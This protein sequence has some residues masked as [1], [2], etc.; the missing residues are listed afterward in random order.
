[1]SS[2]TTIVAS[3]YRIQE[4]A[5]QIRDC[6]NRPSGMSVADWCTRNGITKANYYY[7]LR[8]VRAACLENIPEQMRGHLMVP[9]E[10]NLLQKDENNNS[11]QEP[12][13]DISIEGVSI[14]V[15]ES[16]P[17]PLLAAVLEVVR[18]AK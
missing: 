9:V 13:L 10:P 8:C 3:Q 6:Q 18:N 14:H 2:E 5:G 12:G 1:M 7:R 17:M 16:T 11:N 4:W 15:T